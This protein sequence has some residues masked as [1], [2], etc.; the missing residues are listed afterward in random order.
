MS[1]FLQMYVIWNKNIPPLPKVNNNRYIA[2]Q[3][4]DE[5]L[6]LRIRWHVG[7]RRYEADIIKLTSDDEYTRLEVYLETRDFFSLKRKLKSVG[8]RHM[9]RIIWDNK[10]KKKVDARQYDLQTLFA[11]TIIKS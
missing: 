3:I 8:L 11:P 9:T 5:E 2:I 6:L 10:P 7:R 1:K 4:G